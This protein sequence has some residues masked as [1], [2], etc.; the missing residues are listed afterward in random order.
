MSA[1]DILEAVSV[2]AELTGTQLS[3]AAKAAM[4]E[5]LLAYSEPAV[6]AALGR[7]RRELKG[8]LTQAEVIERIQSDDGRPSANEAWGIAL[9]AFDEAVTVVTNEE[10]NE[11]MAA[12]RPVMD[13]GDEVGARMAFRDCY[14][15]VVRRNRT[16][17]ITPKWYPSLGH[18]PML[19]ID[20]IKLAE[21]RGLLTHSQAAAYL[22]APVTAEEAAK[23]RAIAGLLTGTAEEMPEDPEFRQRIG[24]IFKMLKKEPAA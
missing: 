6:I 20:A 2:V 10:I 16:T 1:R 7:C 19:R 4:V 15:R 18:D 8:R 22:P 3:D 24:D 23:G 13:E 5:D 9:S 17:G 12:A 21:D 11:A 14:D